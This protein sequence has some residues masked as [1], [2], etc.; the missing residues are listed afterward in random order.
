MN[1]SLDGFYQSL[2]SEGQWRNYL[3][4]LKLHY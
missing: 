4:G 2:F 1:I 3:E